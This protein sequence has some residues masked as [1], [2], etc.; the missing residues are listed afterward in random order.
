LGREPDLNRGSIFRN[1]G[2]GRIC[3][4][5][6][7]THDIGKFFA[8]VHENNSVIIEGGFS[9]AELAVN[10]VDTY[11]STI[12]V[13]VGD[14]LRA[15]SAGEEHAESTDTGFLEALSRFVIGSELRGFELSFRCGKL[16]GREPQ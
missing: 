2:K 14:K 8:V 5:L 10:L 4:F 3:E 12:D 1:G 16:H 9:A 15:E 7:F 6:V 13:P 11:E